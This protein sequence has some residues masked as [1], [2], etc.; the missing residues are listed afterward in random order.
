M[1]VNNKIIKAVLAGIGAISMVTPVYAANGT[2]GTDTTLGTLK[3]PEYFPTIDRETGTL[4]VKYYDDSEETTPIEGAEFTIY[5]VANV[6]T[7]M[8]N[9]ENGAYLPLDESLSFANEDGSPVEDA[10][11]YEASVLDVYEN[12]ESLGISEETYTA[13]ETVGSDGLAIFKDVPV[14]AYLVTETKTIRY[15]IRSTSFLVS[16]PEMEENGYSWNF[17]VTCNPKQILA[18][19]LSVTKQ[20]LGKDLPKQDGTFTVQLELSAEGEYEATLPNG[21][22]GTVHNGSEV[23]IKGGQ[24]LTIR[25]LPAGTSYKVTEKEANGVINAVGYKTTYTNEEGKIESYSEQK[26]TITNDSTEFDTGAGF[27]GMWYMIAGVSAATLL[28]FLFATRKKKPE[29]K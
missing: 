1:Q 4:T 3:T 10:K 9:G 8:Q 23:S 20:I 5:K 25:D 16:V 17:D 24:T 22:E 15:H 28:I 12:K 11:A 26:S 21:E 2:T 14:G 29:Q 19:D 6:G 27:R 7:S 18:G 13:T